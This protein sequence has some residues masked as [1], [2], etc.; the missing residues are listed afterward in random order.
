MR[1]ILITGITG[2]AGSF[3][4]EYL[5]KTQPDV[6]ISGTYIVEKSLENVAS[7]KE[8]L[9]LEKVDLTDFSSVNQLI[10]KCT[11]DVVFHLAAITTVVE[12]FQNPSLVISN[13]A[14]AQ[15]NI[16]ESLRQENLLQSKFILISSANVYGNVKPENLPID[17]STPL[18]PDNPYAVSKITQDFIG[19]QYF[20]T[21]GMPVIRLRP[22]NHLGPRLSPQISI[23]HF[24]QQIAMIEK[25]KQEAVLKVGNLSTKRDFS[26]VHDIVRAYAL[27][28]EK[29]KPGDVYNIGSGTAYKIEDILNK[30]LKMAKVEIKI[31]PDESRMRPSDIQELRCDATKF[32]SLT[33]WKTE[34]PLDQTLKD[35]L[36]YWRKQV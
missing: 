16:L 15:I 33:G 11:P 27:A 5:I 19:L 7:I 30:L 20:L 24:A 9:Q 32:M 22:F 2:F 6:K 18:M 34:I 10:K 26:D 8:K 23:S 4:A 36:E 1:K 31:V 14:T 3:L 29:G 25:G 13:N 35:T 12:G 17:E 21:Y 28:A